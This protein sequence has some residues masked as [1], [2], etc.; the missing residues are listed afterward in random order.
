M[1][2]ITL[3]LLAALGSAMPVWAQTVANWGSNDYGQSTVPAGLV[4][5]KSVT[6]GTLHS[7]ALLADGTVRLWGTSLVGISDI[8]A[9]LSN[10]VQ[11]DATFYSTF[12]LKSDGTVVSWGDNYW[13]QIFLA[14]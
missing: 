3:L 14:M 9:G 12:A 2:T 8:P 4:N 5:P 10:V 13:T 1:K 7:T 6:A 11:L